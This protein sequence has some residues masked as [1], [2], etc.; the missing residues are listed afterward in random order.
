MAG[1]LEKSEAQTFIDHHF[2]DRAGKITPLSGGDWSQ[3]YAF[4]RRWETGRGSFWSPWRGLQEGPTVAEWSSDEL[5]IPRVLELGQTEH[6][7]FAYRNA[8][9]VTFWTSSIASE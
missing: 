9:K 2:G 4:S 6:G 7:Y 5:P 1:I 3:A 8:F